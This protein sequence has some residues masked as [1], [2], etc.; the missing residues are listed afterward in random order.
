[1][2]TATT[3]QTETTTAPND[4]ESQAIE[5]QL[6]DVSVADL[7]IGEQALDVLIQTNIKSVGDFLNKTNN[8]ENLQLITKAGLHGDAAGSVLN[9]IDDK[10]EEL[11]NEASAKAASAEA[12]LP[13]PSKGK[14][15]YEVTTP[16]NI[17]SVTHRKDSKHISASCTVAISGEEG[18]VGMNPMR[19]INTFA[20]AQLDMEL[21]QQGAQQSLDGMGLRDFHGV[22]Q[23]G[24]VSVKADK[25]SI[26][27]TLVFVRKAVD[28]NALA[29]YTGKKAE[30]RCTNKAGAEDITEQEDEQPAQAA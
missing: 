12:N 21:K 22:A 14:Q 16:I 27:F 20:G 17:G 5:N 8:G 7:D 11:Q 28:G 10:R 26:G 6:S 13:E 25:K 30:L 4:P 1:M 15:G 18:V 2:T 23:I 9:A 3:E 19:A 24:N 29:A